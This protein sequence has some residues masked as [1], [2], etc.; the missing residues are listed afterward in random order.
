MN[1]QI[2]NQNSY[3]LSPSI[4]W[5][6]FW[7]NYTNQKWLFSNYIVRLFRMHWPPH[8][9]AL[10][11]THPTHSSFD[12]WS[13]LRFNNGKRW[14][15]SSNYKWTN[16][17]DSMH[18]SLPLLSYKRVGC[19]CAWE[20]WNKVWNKFLTASAQQAKHYSQM[21]SYVWLRQR[22]PNIKESFQW[23]WWWWCFFLTVLPFFVAKIPF[24][25]NHFWLKS[26]LFGAAHIFISQYR[27]WWDHGNYRE[28]W[29]D[30][31]QTEMEYIESL[32]IKRS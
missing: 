32:D 15:C 17:L 18:E 12:E 26:S 1:I 28:F 11:L 31:K 30:F 10:C 19:L 2:L 5:V 9:T 7:K 27:L 23:R 22:N 4:I 20:S 8:S 6:I 24:R 14:F 16:K 25:L 21:I 29:C 13:L 3:F